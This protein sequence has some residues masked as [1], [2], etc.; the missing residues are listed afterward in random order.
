MGINFEHKNIIF[1]FKEEFPE[2]ITKHSK[3]KNPLCEEIVI[4]QVKPPYRTGSGDSEK[5]WDKNMVKAG[6]KSFPLT[7]TEDAFGNLDIIF[8][9][10]LVCSVKPRGRFSSKLVNALAHLIKEALYE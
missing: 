1:S 10:G 7:F 4:V 5:L 3:E 6:N 8:N 9:K 2:F